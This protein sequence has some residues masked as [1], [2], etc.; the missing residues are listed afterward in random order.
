MHSRLLVGAGRGV[1]RDLAEDPGVRGR[2]A[3]D[4]HGVAAGL[5]DH[6][7]RVFRRA[8]VS[9]ADH[10]NVHGLFY[11][12]DPFPASLAGV[13]LFAGAGVQGHGIQ[14]L[15]FRHARQLHADDLRIVPTQ[16]ELD[17]EGNRD[18][19]AHCAEDF[20]DPRQV[21]Q[22]ARAAVTA[23]HALGG[24]AEV[25]VHGVEPGVLD[26]ARGFGQRLGVGPEELRADGVLVVV[27]REVAAALGFAHAR[28][29]V[30]RG[31]FGH[32]E[33]AAGLLVADISSR[34]PVSPDSADPSVP[35]WSLS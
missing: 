24:A 3:A 4:H 9:V 17:G 13:G 20:A 28:K 33:P 23:H 22:Q 29:A 5:G 15:G 8:D 31:E 6:R 32:Q 19:L 1:L 26:D 11:R 21:A 30:G 27:E 10:R 7:G 14:P 2:G 12:G 18:R 34:S 35:S 25:Q 16:A